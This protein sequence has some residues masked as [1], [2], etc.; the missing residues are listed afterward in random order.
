MITKI[1]QIKGST[2]DVVDAWDENDE[3]Q[4][5]TEPDDESNH[6]KASSKKSNNKDPETNRKTSSRHDSRSNTRPERS[7]VSPVR[8]RSPDRKRLSLERGRNRFSPRRSPERNRTFRDDR[9]RRSPPRNVGQFDRRRPPSQDRSRHQPPQSKK[10]FLEEM[11]EQFIKE[12]RRDEQID[13]MLQQGGRIDLNIADL[14]PEPPR[15]FQNLQMH[16][17]NQPNQMPGFM[18]EPI[19]PQ[20]FNPMMMHQMPPTMM[21]MPNMQFPPNM[22]A[23]T[24]PTIPTNIFMNPLEIMQ[25]APLPVPPPQ[26]M[27]PTCV[28]GIEAMQF[29]QISPPILYHNNNN[30][31]PKQPVT[32]VRENVERPQ[33]KKVALSDL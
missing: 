18:N 11:Q 3:V 25:P 19:M 16:F 24:S 31:M 4:I 2:F 28:P 8:R 10:S 17:N 21:N 33:T 15:N 23:V 29:P 32:I 7:R 30:G 13:Q 12:G 14:M 20:H 1:I 5:K 27:E 26:Q 22:H 9:F 6:S